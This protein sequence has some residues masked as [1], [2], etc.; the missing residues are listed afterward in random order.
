[1]NVLIVGFGTAG[2]FYLEI[3]REFKSVNKIYIFDKNK[4]KK[5]NLYETVNFDAS[6]IS[7]RNIK[8]AIV[9]T[10]SNLQYKYAKILLEQNINILIEKPFVLKLSDAKKLIK[11]TT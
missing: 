5:S 3:L 6:E 1:M 10:P 7:K 4:I 8:Y 2:K 9:A 11:L